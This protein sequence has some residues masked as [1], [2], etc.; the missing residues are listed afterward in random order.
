MPAAPP[1]YPSRPSLGEELEPDAGPGALAEESPALGDLVDQVEAAA[2]LVLRGGLAPVRQPGLTV[3]HHVH[4]YGGAA[5]AE[6]EA[7][8]VDDPAQPADVLEAALLQRLP[9]VGEP[10]PLVGALLRELMCARVSDLDAGAQR[11]ADTLDVSERTLRRRC[12]T[13]LGYGPKTL[14]RVLRFRR[15]RRS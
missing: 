12:T 1:R 14:E 15:S 13:A 2:A 8:L 11:L 7:R 6:L 3:I 10:D 4:V 9:R 5:A